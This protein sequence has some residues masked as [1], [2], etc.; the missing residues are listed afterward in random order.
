MHTE[1]LM[2]AIE[3]RAFRKPDAAR[4]EIN[5]DGG[6]K[7]TVTTDCFEEET[8]QATFLGSFQVAPRTRD[9]IHHTILHGA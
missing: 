2:E 9:V 6:P 1:K 3:S 5:C 7:E 8:D 4:G